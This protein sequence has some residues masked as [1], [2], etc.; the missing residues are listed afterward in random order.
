MAE[1]VIGKPISEDVIN[2]I[3]KRQEKM[4]SRN[5]DNDTLFFMNSNNSWIKLTSGANTLSAQQLDRIEE[6]S[7]SGI[8]DSKLAEINVLGGTQN[9]AGV[10]LTGYN[11]VTRVDGLIESVEPQTKSLYRNTESRGFRPAPGITG[12]SVKS[13]G[14]YGTLRET[15]VKFIVWSLEDLDIL[16]LIYLRPGFSMLLEWGHTAYFT[17]EG[18]FRTATETVSNFFEKY[19]SKTEKKQSAQTLVQNEIKKLREAS[20]Y[21]Y[22]GLFGYVKNFNWS[23]RP[24]GGYDCS[25][26]IASVGSLIE[27]LRADIGI[28]NINSS[29]ID[30]DDS[31]NKDDT[32]HKNSLKS[33]FHF[34]F[35]YLSKY[36]GRTEYTNTQIGTYTSPNTQG[37][38]RQVSNFFKKLSISGETRIYSKKVKVEGVPWYKYYQMDNLFWMPISVVFDII[39]EYITLKTEEGITIELY[40][41][42]QDDDQTA[43]SPYELESKYVTSEY[44]FAVD[45]FRVQLPFTPEIPKIVST[46][47]P[48]FNT[49][50]TGV[51]VGPLGIT[52]LSIEQPSLNQSNLVQNLGRHRYGDKKEIFS[53]R[54]VSAKGGNDDILNILVTS[55]VLLE[56][57]ERNL[58][59]EDSQNR[60]L[61]SIIDNLATILTDELGGINEFGYHFDEVRNLFI[62]VDRKNTPTEGGDFKYPQLTLTGLNTT[63]ESLSMSS[64][65]SSKVA[66]QI[67]IAA[68]GSSNNYQENVSEILKWNTG[69]VDRHG[70]GGT[71]NVEPNTAE[72]A[73]GVSKEEN[74]RREKWIITASRVYKNAGKAKIYDSAQFS[75]LKT[76]HRVYT[77]T[78][79]LDE[80]ISQGQAQ[81]GIIPVELSFTMLGV[82]GMDI[83]QAFKISPGVLPTKYSGAFGFIITGLEHTIGTRWTTTVKT[84][85]YTLQEPS[86]I[87][88]QTKR[89]FIGSPIEPQR[90]V[91]TESPILISGDTPNANLLRAFMI[92]LGYLEKGREISNGGDITNQTAKMGI[93]VLSRLKQALPID[94]TITVTSGNDAYHQNLTGMSRHKTG[95]GLDFVIAP[96]HRANLQLVEKELNIFMFVN[97]PNFRYLNEYEQLSSA[98]TGGHFHISFGAGTEA[99]NKLNTVRITVPTLPYDPI[100]KII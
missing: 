96:N 93:A 57:F 40:S 79:V 55:N 90:S 83:A 92:T 44:H 21:N 16:E 84:Q 23:F 14:T 82:S 70:V 39:N 26:S 98:G 58:E 45:P 42:A 36:V 37:V 33:P 48:K 35:T 86:E 5:R 94:T 15:D 7:S 81:K 47:A 77:N 12:V 72:T 31:E 99:Q 24:D 9:R 85:F 20:G 11:P 29:D 34:L 8:G 30:R 63:V 3:L 19:K 100:Y 52:G 65:L 46:I 67:A 74:E 54:I 13:R 61:R 88:R 76:Y 97:D 28:Q 66:S 10:G 25:I 17:T 43:F 49:S 41:G 75:E 51:I 64:K 87:L 1:K 62:L 78:Y 2:Q 89:D 73:E 22:D 4:G 60:D 80:L 18:E 68:Q 69:V 91:L 95:R 38:P 27:G 6:F 50:N 71:Y 53:D 59:E 32:E 56:L